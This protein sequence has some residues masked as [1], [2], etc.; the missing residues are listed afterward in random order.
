MTKK[1]FNKKNRIH[2]ISTIPKE[3]KSHQKLFIQQHS[4]KA[5]PRWTGIRSH[6]DSRQQLKNKTKNIVIHIV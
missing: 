4:Q 3:R 5:N 2:N 6:R 1:D